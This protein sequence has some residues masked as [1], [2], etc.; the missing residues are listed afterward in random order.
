MEVERWNCRMTSP[1]YYLSSEKFNKLLDEIKSAQN[2]YDE[3]Y[4]QFI[5]YKD[6]SSSKIK[7]LEMKLDRRNDK[8]QSVIDK[9]SI[10]S[11][12]ML[13][14]NEKL[15]VISISVAIV[16]NFQEEMKKIDEKK[17]SFV[18]TFE[19]LMLHNKQQ[20]QDATSMIPKY[21]EAM[22]IHARLIVS[23][24]YDNRD[25]IINNSIVSF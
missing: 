8:L 22:D 11:Q 17:D 20:Y 9:V 14:M 13:K 15:K 23:Q 18:K 25:K 16:S 6:K 12:E 4:N 2:R 24:L 21:K 7:A 3:L 5:E 19:T 1:K 10:A